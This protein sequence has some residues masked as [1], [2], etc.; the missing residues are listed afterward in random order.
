M[1]DADAA[2]AVERGGGVRQALSRLRSEVLN[3]QISRGEAA[4]RIVAVVEEY[5]PA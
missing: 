1:E 4:R 2:L 5:G 3:G